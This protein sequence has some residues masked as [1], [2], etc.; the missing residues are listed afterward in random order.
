MD[1]YPVY[2]IDL[3]TTIKGFSRKTAEGYCIVL[4]AR[5]SSDAQIRAY[6]HEVEHIERGD[7]DAEDDADSIERRRHKGADRHRGS[8]PQ[9]SS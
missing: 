7:F 8:G 2:Y 5:I 1:I 4:N 9:G 6:L 3:P